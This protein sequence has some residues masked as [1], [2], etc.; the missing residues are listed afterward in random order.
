MLNV[1][2]YSVQFSHSVMSN[3]LQPHGLQHTRPPCL[4]PTPR[5]CSNSYPLSWWCHPTISSSCSLLEKCKSKLQ[6]DITSYQ[7][8]WPSSKSLQTINFWRECGEKGTL[9]HCWWECKLIQPLWK[10][11]RGFLKK[12][13]IKPPYDPAIP[14]LGAGNSNRA[15]VSI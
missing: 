1:V 3:S 7:S 12:L 15:S 6:W 5:V 11:V 10:T 8:E 4:S 2:Y 14:L 9:F 13:R